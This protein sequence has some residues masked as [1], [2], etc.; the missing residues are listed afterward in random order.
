MAEKL[1][2]QSS[3][4]SGSKDLGFLNELKSSSYGETDSAT[5]GQRLVAH[6]KKMRKFRMP[7]VPPFR[8]GKPVCCPNTSVFDVSSCPSSLP[9]NAVVSHPRIATVEKSRPLKSPS[10]ATGAVS[11]PNNPDGGEVRQPEKQP[12]N[13]ERKAKIHLRPCYKWAD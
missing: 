2:P 3:R 4:P 8:R 7:Q 9:T 11:C 1:A 6:Q 13:G 12:T 5:E 10:I